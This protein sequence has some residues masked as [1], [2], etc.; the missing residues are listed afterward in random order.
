[1]DTETTPFGQQ[2]LSSYGTCIY[3][4][5]GTGLLSLEN[6]E[7]VE[8]K[9]NAG[10]LKNGD[11][12]LLCH[13]P[14]PCLPDCPNGFKGETVEGFEV[15]A[16]GSIARGNY[17]PV[18]PGDSHGMYQAYHLDRMR[19]ELK[20]APAPRNVSFGLTNF[21]FSRSESCTVNGISVGCL[22]LHLKQ[23][24][25][26]FDLFIR[27]VPEYQNVKA[28]LQT[29]K[30]VDV[31]CEA[32][33]EIPQVG[34]WKQLEQVAD[35]LCYVLSIARG[36]KVNWVYREQRDQAGQLLSRTHCSRIPK[37]YCPW[38]VIDPRRPDETKAFV[39]GAYGVYVE[40]RE[41]YRLDRGVID[42]YLDAKAE[43]DYVQIR[44]AKLA[45]A[46]EMLKTVFLKH[47]RSPV[48]AYI[49][50]QQRLD[51]ALVEGIQEAIREKLQ[52]AGVKRDL[53][54][55]MCSNG[56]IAGLNRRSFRHI[57]EKFRKDIKL[58]IC[59]TA[60]LRFVECRNKLVH[61]GQFYCKAA[62]P[63]ERKNLKPLSSCRA[64]YC[65]LV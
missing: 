55:A 49:M 62:T 40:K 19:V 63:E 52:K 39:E 45:V 1:M 46:M 14:E 53:A 20:T 43:G 64:E 23:P 37:P 27:A 7:E 41:G 48:K 13:S 38:P 36:T 22:S 51:E 30:D 50:D 32:V 25:S 5:E 33:V 57:L 9:F 47:P 24:Q 35:D 15:T 42:A 6:D 26:E 34:D 17:L 2:P 54:E 58:E 16:S 56:K 12:L 29:V 65:F 4:Y 59:D 10:Q 31:T 18:S 8:C 11:V 44:G 3:G 60:F 21:V 61:E 28:R